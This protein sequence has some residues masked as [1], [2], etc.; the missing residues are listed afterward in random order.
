MES[1]LLLLMSL[2]LS[3]LFFWFQFCISG[4]LRCRDATF[5]FTFSISLYVKY[6]VCKQQIGFISCPPHLFYPSWQSLPWQRSSFCI[7]RIILTI[8]GLELSSEPPVFCSFFSP[9]PAW[10]AVNG[11]IIWMSGLVACCLHIFV[12]ILFM[13]TPE[14]TMW[15][16]ELLKLNIS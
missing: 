13:I 11:F 1:F 16:P 5:I 7:Y 8:F 14:I 2:A 3:Q 6:D 12:S 4:F 10:S 15:F 9:L